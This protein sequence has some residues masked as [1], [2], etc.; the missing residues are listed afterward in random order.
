MRSPTHLPVL[1]VSGAALAFTACLVPAAAAEQRG[2]W[3]DTGARF[4][5][6]ESCREAGEAGVRNEGWEA[7]D[8][9]GSSAPWSKYQLWSLK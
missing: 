5:W 2:T 1:G 9:K 4:Y 6:Y 7:W 8:C 3:R